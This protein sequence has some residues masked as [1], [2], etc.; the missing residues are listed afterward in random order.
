[1]TLHCHFVV[2]L[3]VTAAAMLTARAGAQVQ[4]TVLSAHASN[5]GV[6]VRMSN[7][8]VTLGEGDE[9]RTHVVWHDYT[10]DPGGPAAGAGWKSRRNSAAMV[11]TYD[12]STGEWSDPVT[13]GPGVD[14]HNNP[15]LVADSTGILHVVYGAHESPLFYRHSLRPND[16]SEWSEEIRCGELLTY[17]SLT[18]DSDDVLHVTARERDPDDLKRY[19]A[20]YEKRPGDEWERVARIVDSRR[21]EYTNFGNCLG[22][23]DEDR[24]HLSF[25]VY[26]PEI[27][28]GRCVGYLRSDDG[29][30]SWQ[31][32]AGRTV[33]LPIPEHEGPADVYVR[34]GDD[35]RVL[36]GNLAAGPD[37]SPWL[38]FGER[39]E[40]RVLRPWLAHLTDRGWEFTDLLPHVRESMRARGASVVVSVTDPGEVW[41]LTSGQLLQPGYT[42]AL[43][44]SD[45]D[46]ATF[47][48]TTLWS[49]DPETDE[50]VWMVNMQRH[51]DPWPMSAPVILYLTGAERGDQVDESYHEAH[52]ILPKWLPG[53]R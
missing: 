52:A 42:V 8:A 33:D 21:T 27:S 9:R 40:D 32:A 30:R 51:V 11:R 44:R 24:L 35:L 28:A 38:T 34:R 20:C 50:P 41:C 22:V 39:T 16:A 2:V 15:A 49:G 26:A 23:D 17:P 37:G 7:K 1:M 6:S 18:C 10:P 14:N 3:V 12:H 45:D 31:T 25:S 46:G 47:T 36:N 43:L 5:R 53:P 29:G 19:L 13:I 4:S 48:S